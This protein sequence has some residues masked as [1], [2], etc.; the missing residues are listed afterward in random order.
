MTLVKYYAIIAISLRGEK[1]MEKLIYYSLFFLSISLGLLANENTNKYEKTNFLKNYYNEKE[2]EDKLKILFN[3]IRNQNNK[4]VKSSLKITE[5]IEKREKWIEENIKLEGIYGPYNDIS[6]YPVGD[7]ILID[8]DSKDKIGYTP[9]IVAIESQNNEIVKLL[10]ENDVD[11]Y[12]KHPLFGKL[13]IHTAAYYENYEAV[14]MLIEKDKNLV[15]YQSEVDGWTPL[16]EAVLKSNVEIVKL[17]LE[18]GANPLI[19]DYNGG[20]VMNMATEFGK[21]EIVKLLRNN[22]KMRRK[23]K[24]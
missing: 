3:G 15:N 7:M 12:V 4:F 21:G 16:Q 17:L 2:N 23:N 20:T 10:L 6:L 14:K 19:K 24:F 9:I 1:M 5:N 18:N 8:I 11:F 22:I 13:T